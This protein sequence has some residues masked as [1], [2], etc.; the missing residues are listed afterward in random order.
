MYARLD[1]AFMDHRKVFIAGEAI[2]KNGPAI[3]IGMFAVGLMWVNKHLTDGHI[4]LA[5]V[6]QFRHV[7]RPLAVANALVRAGLWEKNG[8]DGFT[9]HD[10]HEFGNPSSAAVRAHRKSEKLRKARERKRAS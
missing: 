5:V 9:I 10:Y 2:G 7:D 1:D 8:G 4:P 3:A 6:R